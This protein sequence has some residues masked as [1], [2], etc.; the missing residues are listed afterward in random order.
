MNNPDRPAAAYSLRGRL[1]VRIGLPLLFILMTTAATA[2]G[3][4][5]Y[6]VGKTYD[7]EMVH[8][9]SLLLQLTEHEISV[10]GDMGLDLGNRR[11]ELS[12][13][14]EKL[15]VFRVSYRGRIVAQSSTA[16]ILQ[17]SKLP[18]GFSWQQA[19]DHRWRFFSFV[20]TQT[21]ITVDIGQ[22]AAVRQE[23]INEFLFSLLAAAAILVFLCVRVVWS[24][25]TRA[26][27]PLVS[28]SQAV[29]K[30]YAYDLEPIAYP[31]A[32]S[33]VLPLVTALNGLL[34][35]LD[36]AL[37]RE[38]ALTDNAAHE[39][40]TPLAAMKMRL[41]V[42]LHQS[43]LSE[44]DR[45]AL[46]QV[47]QSLNRAVEMTNQ[48][49]DLS[50]LENSKTEQEPVD[51]SAVVHS[52]VTELAPGARERKLA[53]DIADGI[54]IDGHRGALYLL[55]RNLLDNAIKFT[56]A[57]GAI[58]VALRQESAHVVL[59]VADNGPGI[60]AAHKD[61]VFERFYRVQKNRSGSGVGLALVR[62]AADMHGARIELSD[63]MP[64]GLIAEVFFPKT[65]PASASLQVGA[66]Y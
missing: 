19:G 30:R 11:V 52:A 38:R 6:R 2:S 56:P 20:D 32:A 44:T 35:R 23:V 28:L 42:L 43:A 17:P 66:S 1:M 55:I 3:F 4:A 53:L 33:E 22:R 65:A 7:G 29:D 8:M 49:L 37:G 64:H 25:A 39:L 62:W 10:G 50:R 61:K 58:T 59:S 63:G 5:S 12:H 27:R 48:L 54:V 16:D 57:H 15:F 41:Q 34:A 21:G 31:Q 26:L 45:E 51:L 13:H 60:P 18:L 9:A 24:G 46:L 47:L 14:H 36:A 40:R